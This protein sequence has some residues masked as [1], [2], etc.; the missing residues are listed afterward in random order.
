MRLSGKLT[1]ADTGPFEFGLI[2]AGERN[3]RPANASCSI[4]WTLCSG[5][6]NLW[7]NNQLVVDNWTKQHPG[8]FFYG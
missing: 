5:R 7:I 2:V 4:V 6:A 1:V 3:L 8:D